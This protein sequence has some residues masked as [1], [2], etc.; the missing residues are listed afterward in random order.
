MSILV[1][2]LCCT[3]TNTEYKFLSVFQFPVVLKL[4]LCQ[5]LSPKL[6]EMVATKVISYI[7]IVCFMHQVSTSS[8]F[9]SLILMEI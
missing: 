3:L 8:L 7:V 2:Y 1:R 5:Q 4:T 6:F 9:F